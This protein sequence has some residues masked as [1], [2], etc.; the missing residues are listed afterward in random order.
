MTADN[1][2]R[3]IAQDYQLLQR[4]VAIYPQDAEKCE[5]EKKVLRSRV[6]ALTTP[7]SYERRGLAG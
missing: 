6:I 5:Q 7:S 3:A 4:H 2:L 1:Q